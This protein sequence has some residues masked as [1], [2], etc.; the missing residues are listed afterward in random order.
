[1]QIVENNNQRRLITELQ[2]KSPA[3]TYNLYTDSS[4]DIYLNI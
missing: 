4:Y 3:I 1:V 2:P